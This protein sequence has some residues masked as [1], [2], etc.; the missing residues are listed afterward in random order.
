MGTKQAKVIA[1]KIVTGKPA[2]GEFTAAA[3]DI[4]KVLTINPPLEASLG[5]EGLS[6]EIKALLPD[7]KD[8]DKLS[9]ATWATLKKLGWKGETKPAKAVI[10]KKPAPG[11]PAKEPKAPKVAATSQTYAMLKMP[12][13]G[14]TQ[15]VQIVHFP[16]KSSLP[17]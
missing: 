6:K 7:I 16:A 3:E 5:E 14:P 9:D 1:R 10:V 15:M 12:A 2:A 13:K 17:R 11:K 8:G 4:S